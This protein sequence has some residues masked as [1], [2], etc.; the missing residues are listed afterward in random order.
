MIGIVPILILIGIIVGI[1]LYLNNKK[2]KGG[3]P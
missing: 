2:D 3:I 1:A